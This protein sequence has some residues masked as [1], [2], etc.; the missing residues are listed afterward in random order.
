[1][2]TKIEKQR[3]AREL[4]LKHSSGVLS[5]ISIDLP[6]YP[7]GS[8]APY[9]AD[10]QCRP[11]IYISHIAQHTKNLVADSRVSL[12]VVENNGDSD[13][14]QAQ[15]RVTCIANAAPIGRDE[16]YISDRYFRYFPSASQYE[17][18]HDFSF[19]RLELLRIRFI[20]G[21]GEIYWVEPDEF[22]TQNPFSAAQE[23]QIIQHMN[24]DHTDALRHYCKGDSAQMVGI[25]ANGF[26]VLKAG[27][28]VRFS[29]ETPIHNMAEARQA[30]VAMAKSKN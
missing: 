29:F 27:K 7:F 19:F 28:K 5:T 16:V 21:F 6:G 22:M 1:M 10:D 18:T 17:R 15:G 14:V 3:A 26:D 8:V 30:L 9:C 13:D 20:A 23:L 25:D 4:F 12:T 2:N 24:N 11:V